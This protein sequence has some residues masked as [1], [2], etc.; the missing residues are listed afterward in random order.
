MLISDCVK[1][2]LRKSLKDKFKDRRGS[3]DIIADILSV[4]REE[5]KKTQIVYKANLNFTRLEH[6]LPPLVDKELIKNT[7]G[8][9][10]TTEKG[11]EF[12]RDYQAM[13]GL[14]N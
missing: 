1:A 5:A 11:R 4:A 9:Y 10:K 2:G 12:L 7:D 3:T 13:K 6:Y 8:E 14:L